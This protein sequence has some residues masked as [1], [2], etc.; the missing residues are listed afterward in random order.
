MTQVHPGVHHRVGHRSSLRLFHISRAMVRGEILLALGVGDRVTISLSVAFLGP[1]L[2]THLVPSFVISVVSQDKSGGVALSYRDRVKL[3]QA[4]L[5]SRGV[6]L[7][8][9]HLTSQLLTASVSIGLLY[10]HL[11][12]LLPRQLRLPDP[13]F[14]RHEVVDS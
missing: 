7:L 12:P 4:V 5:I 14:Q 1:F 10:H 11:L 3:E 8:R 2:E 6:L 13:D 9:Q